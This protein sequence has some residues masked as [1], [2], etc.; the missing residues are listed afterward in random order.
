[1]REHDA[2]P[3]AGN[4][5][6]TDIQTRSDRVFCLELFGSLTIHD[7]RWTAGRGT[8]ALVPVATHREQAWLQ[9][10]CPLARDAVAV[11]VHAHVVQVLRL[12]PLRLQSD[13]AHHAEG[14]Q[15]A[16][17]CLLQRQQQRGELLMLWWCWMLRVR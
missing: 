9:A 11:A 4:G 12:D 3:L 5:V 2:A 13:A 10:F 17:S 16:A 1:M 8:A 15:R 7:V 6:V 14:A